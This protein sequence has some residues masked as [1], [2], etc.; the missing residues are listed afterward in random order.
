[1]SFTTKKMRFPDV[2]RESCKEHD[3]NLEE[4]TRNMKTYN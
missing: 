4:S 3:R 1:M 2:S